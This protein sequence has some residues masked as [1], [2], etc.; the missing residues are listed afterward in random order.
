MSFTEHSEVIDIF[1]KVI[2]RGVVHADHGSIFHCIFYM[3]RSS[4]RSSHHISLTA[5]VDEDMLG[6]IDFPEFIE[7]LFVLEKRNREMAAAKD[8]EGNTLAIDTDATEE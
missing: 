3:T 7:M 6:S 1:N 8:M 4:H 2:P 5:Q